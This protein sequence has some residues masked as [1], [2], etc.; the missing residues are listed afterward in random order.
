MNMVITKSI[1]TR[2]IP[3]QLKFVHGIHDSMEVYDPVSNKW[4]LLDIKM[5]GTLSGLGLG[6]FTIIHKYNL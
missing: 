5:P 6:A 3:F 1:F 4:T 2:V